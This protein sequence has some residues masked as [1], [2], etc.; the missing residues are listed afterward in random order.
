MKAHPPTPI[1]WTQYAQPQQY[2]YADP[3]PQDCVYSSS[4]FDGAK[5]RERAYMAETKCNV[6]S[7]FSRARHVTMGVKG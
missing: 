1:D 2:T 5:A 4:Q 7:D 3:E 6:G